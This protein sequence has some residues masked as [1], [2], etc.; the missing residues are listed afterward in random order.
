MSIFLMYTI[1]IKEL[2]IAT[3]NRWVVVW[4]ETDIDGL[5]FPVLAS[6]LHIVGGVHLDEDA[7]PTPLHLQP[8][9]VGR[10]LS[11]Q[12]PTLYKITP[13]LQ[14]QHGIP[15]DVNKHCV[16]SFCEYHHY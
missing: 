9:G 1:I 10:P 15:L 3:Y 14:Q 7:C 5:A 12:G 11:I 2:A 16:K 13:S 4:T 6:Q 8:E